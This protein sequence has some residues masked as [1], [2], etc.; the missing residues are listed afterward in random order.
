MEQHIRC[1]EVNREL[2]FCPSCT[3][4]VVSH[5]LIYRLLGQLV[6]F[7][8][9]TWCFIAIVYNLKKFCVIF[10]ARRPFGKW[11]TTPQFC[12]RT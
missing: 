5:T 3:N 11:P 4:L 10:S 12:W 8:W 2:L 7:H 6:L 1:S 9:L